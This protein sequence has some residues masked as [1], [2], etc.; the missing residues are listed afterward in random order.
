MHLSVVREAQPELADDDP[1]LLFATTAGGKLLLDDG[2]I[3]TEACQLDLLPK[4]P[5][6]EDGA[7][8]LPAPPPPKSWVVAVSRCFFSP[9]W[10]FL[11]ND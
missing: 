5:E 9:T 6:P 7:P 4:P 3:L 8:L 11:A 1:M 10:H 2:A